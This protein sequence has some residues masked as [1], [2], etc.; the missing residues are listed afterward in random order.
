[1]DNVLIYGVTRNNYKRV[2]EVLEEQGVRWKAGEKPTERQLFDEVYTVGR[3]GENVLTYGDVPFS[4]RMSA[5][6]FLRKYVAEIVITRK[7]RIVTAKD[8]R[9]NHASA[10]CCPED[11]FNFYEGA[12]L[13]L[14]RLEDKTRGIK[15]GDRV[16]VTN[17]GKTFSTLNAAYFTTDDELRRYVYGEE[18]KEGNIYKVKR[19]GPEGVER[20]KK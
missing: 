17:P 19:V 15:A 9:G 14:E 10:R 4:P 16:I 13:A 12:K 20:V 2:L 5:E 11:D 7:G 3:W 18:P 6:D 8:R 1:M